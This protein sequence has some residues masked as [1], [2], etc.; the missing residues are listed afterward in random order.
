MV[1]KS[2]I[3]DCE[4]T[5]LCF[6]EIVPRGTGY[7]NSPTQTYDD[8]CLRGVPFSCTRTEYRAVW[9]KTAGQAL[10]AGVALKVPAYPIMEP[11]IREQIDPKV[12]EQHLALVEI[13]LDVDKIAKGR[14]R[15]RRKNE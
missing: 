15:V 8:N 9:L 1:L 4:P 5:Y 7:A 11:A 10:L 14:G 2:Q 6:G 3:V 12:Y 13:R